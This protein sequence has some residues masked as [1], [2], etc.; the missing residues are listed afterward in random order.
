MSTLSGVPCNG[1]SDLPD[2]QTIGDLATSTPSRHIYKRHPGPIGKTL[3]KILPETQTACLSRARRD[4]TFPLF[5]APRRE[6]TLFFSPS[7]RRF[8]GLNRAGSRVQPNWMG[9]GFSLPAA[10]SERRR[11]A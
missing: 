9:T 10:D 2:A 5:T 8:F 3:A 6:Q 1:I 7:N 4:R 11:R